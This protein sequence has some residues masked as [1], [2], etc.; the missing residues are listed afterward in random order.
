ME[1]L[2][3]DIIAKLYEKC[4]A[5]AKAGNKYLITRALRSVNYIPDMVGEPLYQ[6]N[7]CH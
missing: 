1:S 6:P 4:E 7:P 2:I 5:E 3:P